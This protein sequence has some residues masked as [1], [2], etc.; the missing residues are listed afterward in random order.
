MPCCPQYNY[1]FANESVTII[2]FVGAVMVNVLYLIDGV[3]TAAG[4]FTQIQKTA[5]QVTVDHGGPATGVIKI[6]T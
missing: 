1:T 6:T 5:T 4:M 2:P 3:W